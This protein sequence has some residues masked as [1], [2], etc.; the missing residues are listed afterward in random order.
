[1]AGDVIMKHMSESLKDLLFKK[2]D[3]MAIDE[4]RDDFH[5]IQAELERLYPKTMHILSFSEGK[6]HITT[7]SSSVASDLR[8]QRTTII[9]SLN[10]QLKNQLVTMRISIR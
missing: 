2:A 6:L 7:R 8:L 10:K 5:I 9:Q 1:M 4:K 3:D